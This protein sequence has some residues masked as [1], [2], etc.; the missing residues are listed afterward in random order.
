[1]VYWTIVFVWTLRD[2]VFEFLRVDDFS[3]E[4]LLLAATVDS[5]GSDSRDEVGEVYLLV[6]CSLAV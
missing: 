6:G 3:F 5:A 1:M 4:V 2:T